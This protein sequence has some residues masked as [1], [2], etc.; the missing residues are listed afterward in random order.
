MLTAYGPHRGTLHL[1]IGPMY[2]SKSFWINSELTQFADTGFK[3]LKIIHSDDNRTDVAT[4]DHTGTTHHSSFK[5][6][7]DKINVIRV[8]DLNDVIDD[9]Y[10]VIGIDEAQFFPELYD[11]I[12]DWVENKGI[13][14][15]V[16]G[17]SGDYNRQKFGKT[18]DLIPISDSVKKL[19]AKCHICL[20][21]LSELN[22]KGNTT[23]TPA[24]FTKRLHGNSNEQKEVGGIDKYIAVCRYHYN[25]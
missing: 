16:A 5:G 8:T 20:K 9:D 19:N 15:R 24:P 2:S 11:K 7:S 23:G 18:L 25:N 4:S 13:H 17:L 22:F 10:H 6:L 12:Y 21:E 1:R 3:C 14:V